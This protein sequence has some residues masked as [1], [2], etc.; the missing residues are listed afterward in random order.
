[1]GD[2][3]A[4]I[5]G[6]PSLPQTENESAQGLRLE[7][8]SDAESDLD[9]EPPR[10]TNSNALA[11]I[12]GSAELKEAKNSVDREMV[13]NG[14]GIDAPNSSES[15]F[16]AE[17][18]DLAP[19]QFRTPQ[20]RPRHRPQRTRS[21]DRHKFE[22]PSVAPRPDRKRAQS[23]RDAKDSDGERRRDTEWISTALAMTRRN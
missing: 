4:S 5:M 2:L 8:A 22:T 21:A 14:D 15:L 17:C 13:G 19:S 23:T 9:F 18:N 10:P 7:F 12:L 16:V 3:M 1:M 20:R 6:I 11:S